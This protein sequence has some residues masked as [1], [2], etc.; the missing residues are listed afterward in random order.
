[1]NRPRNGAMIQR[2]EFGRD[3][4]LL[5]VKCHASVGISANVS[6]RIAAY[7]RALSAYENLG[8]SIAGACK[9]ICKAVQAYS[10]ASKSRKF[11]RQRWVNPGEQDQLHIVSSRVRSRIYGAVKGK[12]AMKLRTEDL[13][14]CSMANLRDHIENHFDLWMGWHNYGRWHIDHIRPCA[15]FDLTDA[16]QAKQC[17]HYTNLRPLPARENISKGSKWKGKRWKKSDTSSAKTRSNKP[18]PVAQTKIHNGDLILK[19]K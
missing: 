9:Q 7:D 6:K 4:R 13:I 8:Y 18:R 11:R 16:S 17:F 10:R 5:C 12:S 3:A 2:D 19:T 14:G 15:S 1:M